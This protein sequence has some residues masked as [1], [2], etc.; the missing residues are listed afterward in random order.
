LLRRYF[1]SR[2]TIAALAATAMLGMHR[3]SG[4]DEPA[5]PQAAMQRRANPKEAPPD[6]RKKQLVLL[7]VAGAYAGLTLWHYYAWFHNRERKP[8]RIGGDG[9]FGKDTY[10]GGADKFGHFWGSA[11]LSRVTTE[12]LVG[13]GWPRL[14]ASLIGVGVSSFLYTVSEIKDGFYWELSPGD[15]I[16]NLAGVGFALIASNVAEIDELIDFRIEYLPSAAYLRKLAKD[17]NVDMFQDYSGQTYLAAFHLK[18]IPRL[19]EPDWMHWARYV[20]L[21]VGFRTRNYAPDSLDKTAPRRQYL[22][23]AVGINLQHLLE[24]ATGH[25]ERGP[26]ARGVLHTT[27]ELISVPYTRFAVGGMER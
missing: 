17:G 8:Y 14:T 1:V 15:L 7:G 23:A 9:W 10:A 13:G 2:R 19:T 11:A 3:S 6:P 16:M 21:I 25:V 18:G 27:F 4:A 22:F 20:D 12:V 5:R 24:V 26:G